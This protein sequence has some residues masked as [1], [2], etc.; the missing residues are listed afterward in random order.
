M[1]TAT[2]TMSGLLIWAVSAAL[3]LSALLRVSRLGFDI[4]RFAGAGYL[5]CSS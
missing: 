1:I 3:G 4:V 2:G 5:T